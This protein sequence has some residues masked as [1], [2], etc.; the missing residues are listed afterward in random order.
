MGCQ[1]QRKESSKG[2]V[3]GLTIGIAFFLFILLSEALAT[4]PAAVPWLLVWT[5]VVICFVTAFI[6]IPKNQ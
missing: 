2:M 5:P 1:A 6:L 3:M 4:K